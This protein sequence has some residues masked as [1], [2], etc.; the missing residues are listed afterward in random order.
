MN[1]LL[2]NSG[3]CLTFNNHRDIFITSTK[4]ALSKINFRNV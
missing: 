4:E 2:N 1:A 3:K